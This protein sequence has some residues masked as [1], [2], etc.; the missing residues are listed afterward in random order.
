MLVYVTHNKHNSSN[1][2]CVG[3]TCKYDSFNWNSVKKTF[4]PKTM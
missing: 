2:V 3:I 1:K 4:S